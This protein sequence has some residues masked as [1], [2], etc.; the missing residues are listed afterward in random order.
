[1]IC[2]GCG[3]VISDDVKECP[4]CGKV[5]DA[6]SCMMDDRIEAIKRKNKGKK[7]VIVAVFVLFFII[8]AVLTVIGVYVNKKKEENVLHILQEDSQEMEQI[9]ND[10]LNRMEELQKEVEDKTRQI[11]EDMEKS[12]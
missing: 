1:M 5:M 3:S 6:D 8:L 7:A 9:M 10:S 2:S 12:E 4:T 11:K